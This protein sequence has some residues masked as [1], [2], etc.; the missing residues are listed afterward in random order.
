METRKRIKV[1]H[2]IPTLDMG[3]AER[4]VTDLCLRL[5]KQRFEP[6]ILCFKRGGQWEQE[7]RQAGIKVIVLKKRFKFDPI[8]LFD[9][10][11]VI[12][13]EKPMLVHTH[14]GGDIFGRLFAGLSGLTVISTEHNLN[15][16][17]SF[18]MR[19]AKG[20]S[21]MYVSAIIAVSKAV[22]VDVAKRYAIPKEKIHVIYNGI[23]I[24]RFETAHIF[25]RP[26]VRIGSI[27]RL[28]PQKGF[29]CLIDAMA[30]LKEENI[31]CEIAGTGQLREYL[32]KKI[33]TYNLSKLIKL[34]GI[35]KDVPKF[36]QSLDMFI[37]PSRWEGL[38]IVIL[39]AGATGLPVIATRVDGIRE[40]I[41]DGVDG[42]LVEPDNPSDLAD[43][44]KSLL[45]KPD[46]AKAMADRLQAKVREHFTIDNMIKKYER[47]YEDIVR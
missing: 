2:I 37:L 4:L 30:M 16:D 3:G 11:C 28:A 43:K 14:L 22:A 26:Q 47:L 45:D 44:I 29:D 19:M 41:N 10:W 39:E 23:D 40:I 18:V 5:D 6:V 24:S 15:K 25:S 35:Q 9:L 21:A 36:L 20:V 8:N 34:I 12:R 13:K 42:L 1:L 38:G 46:R 7:L 27:G 17:E 31:E 33:N 32:E